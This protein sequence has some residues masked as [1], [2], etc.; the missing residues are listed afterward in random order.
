MNKYEILFYHHHRQSYNRFF[1]MANDEDDAKRIFGLM[2]PVSWIEEVYEIYA[3]HF[4]TEEE[5]IALKKKL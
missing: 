2:Y 3:E 4:W 5:V 1:V